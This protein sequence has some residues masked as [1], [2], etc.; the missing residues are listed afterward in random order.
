[1]TSRVLALVFALA[2]ATSA[3]AATRT[4][5]FARHAEKADPQAAMASD[6]LLSEAG[7]ARAKEL[8]R[9]LADAN[10]R[11]IY[12][13]QYHR[14]QDTAAPVAKA[15]GVTP[16]VIG[17]GDDYVKT[18]VAKLTAADAPAGTTLVISHSNTIPQILR[19]LG[20]KDAPDIA[21]QQYDDLF[22][23]VFGDGGPRLVHLRY[24][25]QAR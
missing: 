24:G 13:T 14:T 2:T 7:Q 18:M 25:A 6:P 16:I 1:M 5:I 4:V 8:A 15:F 22:I 11:T 17:A 10:I 12:V 21:D 9:V 20:F 3:L 23:A 19:A